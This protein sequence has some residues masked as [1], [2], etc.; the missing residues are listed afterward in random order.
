MNLQSCVILALVL[1]AGI[2][3]VIFA[4]KGKKR[5]CCGSC[6]DCRGCKH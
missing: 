3:A 6:S 1:I 4:R 2:A 5:G